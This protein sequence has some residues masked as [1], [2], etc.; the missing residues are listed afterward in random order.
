MIETQRLADLSGKIYASPV[1]AAGHVYITARNGTTL[2]I[3]HGADLSPVAVN[4]LDDPIDASAAIA[5]D[6]LFL[7]GQ[8]HLYCIHRQDGS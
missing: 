7:R 5:G 2:V 1:V 6:R 4:R 3:E 8:K